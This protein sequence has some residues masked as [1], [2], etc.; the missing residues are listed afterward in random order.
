[1]LGNPGVS[2]LG[3]QWSEG[4]GGL[5]AGGGMEAKPGGSSLGLWDEAVKSQASLRN[6]GLKTSRS[7]P[8]LRCGRRPPGRLIPV[9]LASHSLPYDADVRLL[10]AAEQ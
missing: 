4:P 2:A 8:S 10:S 6:M 3:A 5:W 9:R 7:S 1:M